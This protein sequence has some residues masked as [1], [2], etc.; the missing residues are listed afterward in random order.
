MKGEEPRL[1]FMAQAISPEVYALVSRCSERFG[2][3][4]LYTGT[5][6]SRWGAPGAELRVFR[7]PRFDNRTLRTRGRSWLKYTA[8]ALHFALRVPGRV[9]VCTFFSRVLLFSFQ[10]AL[11][12]KENPRLR[13]L[14]LRRSFSV[15]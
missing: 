2:T 5:D 8:A 1:L 12:S 14:A 10:L 15:L 3:T 11:A 4:W 6:T 9:S 13:F 7:G